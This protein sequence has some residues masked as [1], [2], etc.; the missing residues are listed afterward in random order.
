MLTTDENLEINDEIP[1]EEILDS[2]D[3]DLSF[4][5]EPLPVEEPSIETLDEGV[6]GEEIQPAIP[7]EPSVPG[8]VVETP[9]VPD[10]VQTELSALRAKLEEVTVALQERNSIKE[11]VAKP[12][13]ISDIKFVENDDDVRRVFESPETFNELLN[14]V[15]RM[16]VEKGREFALA[17]MPAIAQAQAREIVDRRAII[18]N[19]YTLN[20]DLATVAEK[21]KE[22]AVALAGAKNYKSYTELLADAEVSVRQKLNMPKPAAPRK[23]PVAAA[24]KASNGRQPAFAGAGASGRKPS[25]GQVSQ[26]EKDLQDLFD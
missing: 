15:M 2:G 3:E 19:F 6:E 7:T 4:L 9:A 20:P 23:P 8:V 17:E 13:E 18:T 26:V 14:K 25:P 22:E 24:P 5:E 12:L 16:G 10:A 11:E 21:V 1:A